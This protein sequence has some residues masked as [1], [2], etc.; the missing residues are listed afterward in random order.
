MSDIFIS[1]ASQDRPKAQ[2][3]AEALVQQGWSV[4]WDRTIPPGKTFDQVIEEALEAA[5]CVI[6]LWSSQS[7]ASHWVKTEAAEGLRRGILVPALIDDVRI[8]LE[9]RRIQTA[10]LV[11]WRGEPTHPEFEKLVRAVA[12]MV[13][14]PVGADIA[15]VE[16]EAKPPAE[17]PRPERLPVPFRHSSVRKAL[18]WFIA[19]VGFVGVLVAFWVFQEPK[20]LPRVEAP[21]S[22]PPRPVPEKEIPKPI[23][24]APAPA[25]ATPPV[26]A[27]P[28]PEAPVARPTPPSTAPTPPKITPAEPAKPTGGRILDGL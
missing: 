6:V 24:E 22:P 2:T 9:F 15:Q 10:Q 23:V 27:T 18:P 28:R 16:G 21:P 1:Y 7:V 26:A 3:L 14:Q 20:P 13:G 25:P 5:K 4:W 17:P 8:P 11:D 19:I 12:N